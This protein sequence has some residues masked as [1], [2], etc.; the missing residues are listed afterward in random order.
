VELRGA[1]ESVADAV[2]AESFVVD[3]HDDLTAS[4]CREVDSLPPVDLVV[5]FG[6]FL[7]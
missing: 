2:A 5:T 4:T 6:H 3:G 1:I 7:I